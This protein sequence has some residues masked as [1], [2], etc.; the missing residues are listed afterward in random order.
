MQELLRKEFTE[1]L[2]QIVGPEHVLAD[3]SH[4]EELSW[5]ALSEGRIH[6]LKRPAITLPLCIVLPVS[7]AEIREIVLLANQEKLPSIPYGGDWGRLGGALSGSP[8]I[9]LDRR[10]MTQVLKCDRDDR[11][12]VAQPG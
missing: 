4:L 8:G 1:K 11:H 12:S 3:L 7:T 10:R 9:V 6:P 2:Y 5:D